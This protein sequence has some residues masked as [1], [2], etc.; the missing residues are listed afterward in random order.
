MHFI[1]HLFLFLVRG[2]EVCSDYISFFC[3]CLSLYFS[4]ITENAF[5][6]KDGK[7][8]CADRKNYLKSYINLVQYICERRNSQPVGCTRGRA[9]RHV[10][11]R[12]LSYQLV[13][14]RKS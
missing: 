5:L 13:N 6:S 3:H 4:H 10:S 1:F 2:P 7:S 14:A 9:Q 8:A 11:T 12:I